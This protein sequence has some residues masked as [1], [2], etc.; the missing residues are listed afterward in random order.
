[1]SSL[2]TCMLIK[3]FFKFRSQ[4]TNFSQGQGH[5]SS[6]LVA[7]LSGK[8]ILTVSGAERKET[9]IGCTCFDTFDL[10]QA[11]F[12]QN[13]E[14]GRLYLYTPIEPSLSR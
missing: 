11:Q 13:H 10:I 7:V 8:F 6:L 4:K 5:Y 1:M 2:P 3:H 9:T 12:W 14:A